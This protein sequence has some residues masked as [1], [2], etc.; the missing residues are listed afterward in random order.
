MLVKALFTGFNLTKG[1]EYRVIFEY[2]S[3]YELMCDDNRIYCR[4][5]TFFEVVE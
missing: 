3:V 2:D 5:K 4:S 1:K